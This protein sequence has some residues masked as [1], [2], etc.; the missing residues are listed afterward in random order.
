MELHIFPFFYFFAAVIYIDLTL[1]GPTSVTGTLSGLQPGLHGFHVHALGDTTNGCMST[2]TLSHLVFYTMLVHCKEKKTQKKRHSAAWC[3]YWWFL[4]VQSVGPHFNPAGKEHGAPEDDNRHAGDLG[5]V[6]VGDDGT[7]PFSS[8]L[9]LVTVYDY[10]CFPMLE[11]GGLAGAI[12][13]S[14]IYFVF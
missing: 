3:F 6:T 1:S 12:A 5:N 9:V 8:L 10:G 2:G 14:S 4:I 13:K 7:F 11:Q